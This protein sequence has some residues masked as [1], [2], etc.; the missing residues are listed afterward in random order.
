MHSF[1]ANTMPLKE[2]STATV[3]STA[4]NTST[5]TVSQVVA[6]RPVIWLMAWPSKGVASEKVV[7]VPASRANTAIRSITRPQAP[8]TR[9]PSSG[10]QASLNFC[11]S[12]PRTCSIKAKHTASTT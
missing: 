1:A 12:R 5:A 2:N 9:R 3:Y 7:A 6:G 8:S 10:R 11:F 4:I